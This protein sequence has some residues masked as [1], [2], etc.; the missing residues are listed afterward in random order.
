MI[1]VFPETGLT[2]I[3]LS[4]NEN[5]NEWN[6]FKKRGTY[7]IHIDINSILPKIDEVWYITNANNVSIVG[8]S[9]T[10]LDETI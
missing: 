10:R 8:I 4:K 5:R 9:E 6:V 1:V 7:C 3:A 2:I